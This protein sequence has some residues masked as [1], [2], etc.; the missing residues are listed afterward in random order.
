MTR[1]ADNEIG[2]YNFDYS[3]A[4]GRDLQEPQDKGKVTFAVTYTQTTDD[5]T[6]YIHKYNKS[7][8]SVGLQ[9]YISYVPYTIERYK[10]TKASN[11]NTS[12][13]YVQ[14]P[15]KTM[16]VALIPGFGFQDYPHLADTIFSSFRFK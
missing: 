6:T 1:D 9:G 5:V 14:N 12:A 4:P 2:F 8:Q 13:I 11:A 7:Q 10:A 16:I 15:E 3:K